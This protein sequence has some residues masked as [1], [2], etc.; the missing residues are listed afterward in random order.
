MFDKPGLYDEIDVAAQ[1]GVS[2]S[3]SKE[4]V[5]CGGADGPQSA[6]LKRIFGLF[7]RLFMSP[8]LEVAAGRVPLLFWS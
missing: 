2:S 5:N 7:E 6:R 8:R 3:A 4:D 1:P